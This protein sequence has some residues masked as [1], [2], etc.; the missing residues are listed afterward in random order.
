MKILC[1]KIKRI[2]TIVGDLTGS[3]LV[4]R[5]ALHLLSDHQQQ[6]HNFTS[7]SYCYGEIGLGA[8]GTGLGTGF[9]VYECFDVL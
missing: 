6:Y 7:I 4:F 8:D 9:I 5:L 1:F 3:Y 2:Q